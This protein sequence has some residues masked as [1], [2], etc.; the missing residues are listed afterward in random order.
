MEKDTEITVVLFRKFKGEIIALFPYELGGQILV[1]CS[2][3][4]HVDQHGAGNP[5]HIVT[6][7]KPTTEAEYAPLKAELES[8]GYN[9]KVIKKQPSDG[10]QVRKEKFKKLFT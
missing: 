3:Y 2:S 10:Y 6:S 8:I 7:S 4:T 9:L 1:T 5:Y